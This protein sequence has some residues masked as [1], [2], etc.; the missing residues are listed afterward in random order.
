MTHTFDISRFCKFFLMECRLHRKMF[1]VLMGITLFE[2]VLTIATYT[3]TAGMA[4]A[5]IE[6]SAEMAEVPAFAQQSLDAYNLGVNPFR[7]GGAFGLLI[8]IVP[9]LLYNFVYHPTKSL[10]YTMLPV[11]WVEKFV[12]AWVQCVI[13]VPMLIFGFS[14]LVAFVGDLAGAQ[15]SYHAVNMKTF[16]TKYYLPTIGIQAVAFWGVFWFKSMKAQKTILTIVLAVI[17][18]LLFL[19]LTGQ[20]NTVFTSFVLARVHSHKFGYEIFGY[21]LMVLLWG[22]ACFKFPRTQI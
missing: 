20:Y 13:V 4:V 3:S 12:S 18:L 11:S 9:F 22:L 1:L 6:N 5:V 10:T 15:I 21:S 17:G 14:L 8:F 2:L 19:H 7:V 16:L